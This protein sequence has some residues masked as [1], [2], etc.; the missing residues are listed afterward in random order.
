MCLRMRLKIK[1]LLQRS[2]GLQ[3]VKTNAGIEVPRNNIATVTGL[4]QPKGGRDG[5]Q[6]GNEGRLY[7]GAG[8][9]AGPWKTGRVNWEGKEGVPG[10]DMS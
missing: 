6:M 7:G 5:F 4:R 8:I 10:G 1:L 9:W 3:G 2:C